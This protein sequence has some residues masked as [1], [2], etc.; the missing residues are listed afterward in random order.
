MMKGVF[1]E[2]SLRSDKDMAEE[3]TYM[4]A[5]L[6]H[7]KVHDLIVGLVKADKVSI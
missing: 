7:I 4:L 1:V 6:Q 5:Q 2:V 3:A